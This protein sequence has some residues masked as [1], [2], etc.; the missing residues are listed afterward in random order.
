EPLVAPILI[1]LGR[2]RRMAEKLDLHLLEL[3]RAERKIPRRDLVAEALAHL[4]NAERHTNAA[5][6]EHVFE[7]HEDALRSLGTEERCTLLAAERADIG[8]EHQVKLARFRECASFFCIRAD[9][10]RELFQRGQRNEWTI[11]RQFGNVF[12][13]QVKE[14]EG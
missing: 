13:P 9:D 10:L 4:S 8:L 14:L 3:S 7:V 2:L 6:I 5:G 1:P 11:P 12:C